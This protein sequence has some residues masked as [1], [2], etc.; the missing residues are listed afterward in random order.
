MW[1]NS[2]ELPFNILVGD[3]CIHSR[4]FQYYACKIIFCVLLI[5]CQEI[6][7]SYKGFKNVFLKKVIKNIRL[8]LFALFSNQ[9]SYWTG[10]IISTLGPL[11]PAL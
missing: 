11:I 7:T 2:D 6:D 1:L 4:Y 10:P 3:L 5:I 9:L 8:A